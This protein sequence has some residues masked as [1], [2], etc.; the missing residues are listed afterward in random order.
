MKLSKKIS[1]YFIYF[2]Q[3]EEFERFYLSNGRT[4]PPIMSTFASLPMYR[5][6]D[7][8]SPII[9]LLSVKPSLKTKG[10]ILFRSDGDTE[11]V[12]IEG[13]S[14]DDLRKAVHSF[15]LLLDLKYPRFGYDGVF[16]NSPISADYLAPNGVEFKRMGWIQYLNYKKNL[17][18]QRKL[19]LPI[20]L[21]KPTLH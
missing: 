5:G 1:S 2:I 14:T 19:S 17:Q 7:R 18:K 21:L 6:K 13:R 9:V 3:A 15:L 8:N 12:K 11:S 20:D 16:K 4:P 10:R